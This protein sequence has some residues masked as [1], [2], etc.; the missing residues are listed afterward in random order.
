MDGGHDRPPTGT[1]RLQQLQLVPNVEV[2]GRFVQQDEIGPL[3]QPTRDDG[4]SPFTARQMVTPTIDQM[5]Q[6][7]QSQSVTNDRA[8]GTLPHLPRLAVRRAS[9]RHHLS[10]QEIRGGRLLLPNE[11]HEPSPLHGGVLVHGFPVEQDIPGIDLSD[12]GDGSQQRGLTH[13]I[14]PD[15][16]S[17]LSRFRREAHVVDDD[18]I[19]DPALHIANVKTRHDSLENRYWLRPMRYRKMGAPMNPVT[20]PRGTSCGAA[21]TRAPT[22]THNRNR[23]PTAAAIGS[24]DL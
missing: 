6:P 15:D 20:T 21:I 7:D 3:G 9:Q 1:Q 23:L 10:Q 12:A 14:D 17:E 24:I 22:S 18:A 11:R 19:T 13:T 16:G 2:V 4:A 8:L 5:I